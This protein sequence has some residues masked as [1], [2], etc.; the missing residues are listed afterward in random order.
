MVY[1]PSPPWPPKDP[2]AT[3]GRGTDV[4]TVEHTDAQI[5][6]PCIQQ[7]FAPSDSLQG[8]CPAHT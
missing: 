7:D 1:P 5:D 3:L 8:H 4:W 2:Q 6:S